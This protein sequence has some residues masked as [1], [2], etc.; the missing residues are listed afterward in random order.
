[1]FRFC[2]GRAENTLEKCKDREDNDGNGFTDCDDFSCSGLDAAQEAIDHCEE[3]TERS[4]ANCTDGKDNDSNG[5]T[6][7]RDNGCRFGRDPVIQAFCQESADPINCGDGADNDN[8]GFT[9]CDDFDCA[10]NPEVTVCAGIP[11]PCE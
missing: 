2:E 3:V 11:R 4:V 1:M 5:F 7:C 9:D 10:Y 8:D 6:D